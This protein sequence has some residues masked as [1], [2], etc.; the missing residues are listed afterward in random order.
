MFGTYVCDS[1]SYVVLS[2]ILGSTAPMKKPDKAGLD[3]I[4][5]EY[6]GMN[7]E[8]NE[9]YKADP[10]GNRTGNGP[11]P[12][13]VETFERVCTDTES[14]LDKTL[15]ARKIAV[16]SAMLKEKLEIMGG[17]VTMAYPMG[18]PEWDTVRITLETV[19][20]LD[21]TAAGM[22]V[23]DPETAELW[24]AS[25][26]FDRNQKVKDRLGKNEKTKVI[27]KLQR[28]GAGAPGREAAISEEEK[29]Q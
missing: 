19:E 4:D 6:R 3:S 16:S 14:V 9:F 7:I 5:E 13:L 10:T 11:G 15:V 2:V 29:K 24:V 27:A 1:G 25:R 20:G 17:A 18:L 12:Q 22:E 26:T 28:P 23:L 21:G 8:K